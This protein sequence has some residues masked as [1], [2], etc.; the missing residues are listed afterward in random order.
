L[1][2]N[3]T[4]PCGGE[5][6][7]NFKTH[8]HSAARYF[9]ARRSRGDLAAA[10]FGTRKG[11]RHSAAGPLRSKI[12][13]RRLAAGSSRCKMGRRQVAAGHFCSKMGRFHSASGPSSSKKGSAEPFLAPHRLHEQRVAAYRCRAVYDRPFRHQYILNNSRQFLPAIPSA[14]G[15]IIHSRI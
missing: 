6:F 10:H 3:G 2:Q 8:R 12:P 15:P 11:C 4:I 13:R 9:T 7:W 5:V 14:I 1:L